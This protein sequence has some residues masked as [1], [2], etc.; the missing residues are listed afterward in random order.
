MEK[1]NLNDFNKVNNDNYDNSSSDYISAVE[2]E[3]LASALFEKEKELSQRENLINQKE[4]QYINH[5]ENLYDKININLKTLDKIIYIL[6]FILIAVLF[7]GIYKAN[8]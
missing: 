3:K 1:H 5:K 7:I 4:Q 6:F 8:S 2:L